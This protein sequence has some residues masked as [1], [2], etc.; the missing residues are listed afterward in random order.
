MRSREIIPLTDKTITETVTITESVPVEA[1]LEAGR[2]MDAQPVPTRNR[3]IYDPESDEMVPLV[4]YCQGI[5]R[6]D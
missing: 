2:I 1:L 6:D 4:I 3:Y 5:D